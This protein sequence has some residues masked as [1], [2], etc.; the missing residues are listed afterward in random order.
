MDP[1]QRAEWIDVAVRE[2]TDNAKRYR[3]GLRRIDPEESLDE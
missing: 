2:Y 3:Q 1:G